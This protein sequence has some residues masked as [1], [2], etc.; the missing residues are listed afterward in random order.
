MKI[1]AKIFEGIANIDIRL[2]PKEYSR[3]V[4]KTICGN[5]GYHFGSIILL[6]EKGL[7]S[8]FSS[9]NLPESYPALVHKVEAPVLSSPSGVAVDS[10]KIVVVQDIMGELRLKPW[11]DLLM[12]FD[13]KTIVWV[14]LFSKGKAF[15][16][17]TLYDDRQR[18][19]PGEE[20][21]I[22]NQLSALF[23]MV[24]IS[25]EYIDETREKA[26]KLEKEIAERKQVEKQLRIAKEAAEAANL[27]KNNFLTTM[28]HE[29]RTPMNAIM[30]FTDI[31]LSDELD[32][33]KLNDLKIIYESAE[34]LLKLIDG[35]LDFAEIESGDI[36]LK[37]I[38]FSMEDMLNRIYERFIGK[39]EKKNLFFNIV[40][41]ASA[42]R[43]VSGDEYRLEQMIANIVDNA[44]K[45]TS[46]GEV[47]TVYSYQNGTAFIRV[48]DT[49][50][51]IPKEKQGLVFSLF[52]QE[53][54]S[55]TRPYGGI[56]LG[57]TIASRLAARMGGKIACQSSPGVG[58]IFTI[59]LP[60]C[61]VQ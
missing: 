30:G 51:G 38:D 3:E 15:G 53:D 1:G 12:Q 34:T 16:T 31:M 58:S 36:E 28:S 23:S 40:R 11:R 14:P 10:G 8:L 39:T 44:V 54:M 13:I 42:P 55:S 47:T 56:G 48:S 17:Y 7:G 49:G 45:F 37:N 60:L 59:E 24:I 32:P 46:S 43:R 19:V 61:E 20:K 5:M 29:L 57:L 33:G 4:L 9:F 50:I 18:E 25:N 22:L 35:I 21:D 2:K 52:S 41:E 26:I 27:A 6:D